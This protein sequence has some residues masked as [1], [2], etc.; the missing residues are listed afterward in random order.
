M[1]KRP[2]SEIASGQV[3]ECTAGVVKAALYASGWE[4][5]VRDDPPVKETL[6]KHLQHRLDDLLV[7]QPDLI[8]NSVL[9]DIVGKLSLLVSPRTGKI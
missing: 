7:G 5:V 2:R 9:R 1:P 3:T 6:R 4:R 8:E